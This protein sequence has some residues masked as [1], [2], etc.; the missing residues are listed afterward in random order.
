MLVRIL[1]QLLLI[2]VL[3][4]MLS[5]RNDT[6]TQQTSESVPE[7]QL[8]S[9]SEND[10]SHP[11]E[12]ELT[13]EG[14][15]DMQHFPEGKSPNFQVYN[16]S[17]DELTVRLDE[18]RI[19]IPA[20]SS[21]YEYIEKGKHV[22]EYDGSNFSFDLAEKERV[23]INPRRD[24]IIMEEIL[25]KQG[26]RTFENRAHPEDYSTPVVML[27]LGEGLYAGPYKIIVK[28]RIIK[29][30]DFGL[31]EM[32]L[33]QI[34]RES[35]LYRTNNSSNGYISY[36]KINTVKEIKTANV[37][38][39]RDDTWINSVLERNIRDLKAGYKVSSMQGNW[40]VVTLP[41]GKEISVGKAS[42]IDLNDLELRDVNSYDK[43]EHGTITAQVAVINNCT[44]LVGNKRNKVKVAIVLSD[45]S[46]QPHIKIIN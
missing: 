14:H 28:E 18:K 20:T 25:Y 5:C 24:S 35:E 44:I 46:H 6:S 23:L 21:V 30:W 19:V 2:V 12:L 31:G 16:S 34:D 17:S 26:Q 9:S 38:L 37:P 29:G 33:R 7:N 32:N 43:G 40:L 4:G 27:T 13:L 1:I 8:D 42:A 36:F 11:S 10:P 41:D 3:Q 22:I 45:K 39:N 15:K